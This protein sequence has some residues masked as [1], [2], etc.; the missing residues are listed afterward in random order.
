MNRIVL[1]SFADKRF[2]N[3]LKRLEEYTKEFPFTERYFHTQDNTFTKSYWKNL[4]P[5]LYRRGYGYWEWK[6][7]L[8]KQYLDILDEYDYLIWSDVGVFWNSSDTAI[9]RFC[10]YI[11]MLETNN[12][13]VLTFQ[14]PYIEQEWTKGDLLNKLDVYDDKNICMSNQLWSGVFILRKAPISCELINSWM[15]INEREKEHVTDKRSVVP[16]K[17]GFKEHRHDQSSFSLLVKKIPHIEISYNETQPMNGDWNCLSDYPIQARRH[18]E[19]NRPLSVVIENKLLR[20][21]RMFLN[22]YF[23]KI[24]NYDFLGKSYP[25]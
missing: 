17:K 20:P 21:W 19:N 13:S 11:T 25:W 22:F 15:E 16:N 12:I 14:E 10:D 23:R 1:I 6:G 2:R 5:W 18:K 8:V 9:K 24:R 4:K 3:A 7:K